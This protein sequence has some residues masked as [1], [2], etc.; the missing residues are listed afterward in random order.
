M[1]GGK[2]PRFAAAALGAAAL[3]VAAPGA[4]S[5]QTHYTTPAT[6]TQPS[7]PVYENFPKDGVP[8]RHWDKAKTAADGTVYHVGVRYTVND[9]ALVLD[10]A[11]TSDAIHWGFVRTSCLDPGYAKDTHGDRIPELHGL[12]SHDAVIEVPFQPPH[13]GD[14]VATIHVT[15][16]GSLRSAPQ[17]FVTGNLRPGDD[18]RITTAHCGTNAPTAWI[19]G[20]SPSAGRWGYLEAMHLDACH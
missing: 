14:S 4:A 7:C 16:A 9:Y 19:L 2:A 20:Y 5:A 12:D 1:S 13:G 15:S 8:D 18:F 3:A 17:S 6:L 10:Q 11:R